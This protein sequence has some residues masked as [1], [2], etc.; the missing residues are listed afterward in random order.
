MTVYFI[1]A[2]PGAADLLTLRAKAVIEK[3]PVILYAGSLVPEEVLGFASDT[4]IKINTAP[5]SLKEIKAEFE[6]AENKNQNIARIHSGDP[7]LYSAIAEQISY[8]KQQ[9]MEFEVIPGVPAFAA[10]SAALGLELTLPEICQT[11]IL[12]RTSKR[13]SAMPDSESLSILG[14]SKA[15]LVIH[16]SAKNTGQITND[17][18]PHYGKDCPVII[19]ADVSWPTEKLIETT[20]EGLSETMSNEGIERTAMIFVGRSL[21][22]QLVRE[23]ALYDENHAR[24]LKPGS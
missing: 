15:M 21:N 18:L 2:G 8:L 7:S 10:A 20:L 13:A 11:V 5:L 3:C 4:A 24:H 14:Q 23:S 17:L 19:A 6:K 1:G 22:Q 12:T 16:L 9:R